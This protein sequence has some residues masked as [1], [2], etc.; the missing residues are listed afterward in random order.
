[1]RI[2]LVQGKRVAILGMA[3]SGTAAAGL[4][5]HYGG[6]PFVSEMK[7]REQ[8]AQHLRRLDELGINYETGGH[9][10][11]A[12]DNIDFIVL[13]PGIPPSAPILREIERRHLP[14]FSEIEIASW[15]CAAQ[16][17]AISGTNG[18]S[19]TTAL[20]AHLLTTAGKK[21]VATGN[22]GSPFSQDVLGLTADD[23]AVVEVSSFQ[24]ERIETFRPRVATL[25]NITPDHL[26]RYR[27]MQAYIEAK[28]RL[29]DAMQPEDVLVLNADDEILRGAKLWGRPT[30]QHFSI[31]QTLSDGVFVKDDEL[32]FSLGGRSGTICLTRDIGIPGPHNVANSAAAAT[33]MLA[34]GLAPEEIARG[35]R[36]FK[37]IPHRI[38]FV[39]EINGVRYINDSKATNV[40]SVAVALQSFTRPLFVIMGGR[41]KA[42]DFAALVPLMRGRVKEVLLIGE[43]TPIIEKQLQGMVP[44]RRAVDIYSALDLA[45]GLA[46]PGDVVLLSPGCA[47]FDQFRDFEDR[48]DKFKQAVHDLAARR[49]S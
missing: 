18:K 41:D 37:G 9:T 33:M 17:V 26:D 29:A 34:L 4:I 15:L 19:T 5:K 10:E 2:D 21:A 43:A 7:P 25:L 38:E 40:D 39:A 49:S 20:T 46:E 30:I 13:S 42:G 31:K 16:I 22:I 45:H 23:F 6:T 12:L 36:S 24:L 28:C 8:V 32:V 11:Q 47:S 1:M 14:V 44:L 3:R 27:E 48:G 35:L